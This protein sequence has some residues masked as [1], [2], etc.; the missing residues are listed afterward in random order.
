VT[1]QTN[2]MQNLSPSAGSAGVA[3][4]RAVYSKTNHEKAV[5]TELALRGFEVFLPTY[6]EVRSWSDRKKKL[7]LPLFP[8]Y[9]FVRLLG[10]QR[11]HVLRCPGVLG[12][13]SNGTTDASVPEAEI[14]GI[15]T[16]AQSGRD[17]SPAPFLQRG[18]RVVLAAG[19]MK[20][21]EGT[22][23]RQRGATRLVVSVSMLERALSVDVD[24]A[25]I[26]PC[27]T[28]LTP[29]LRALAQELKAAK[30]DESRQH[31]EAQAADD[32]TFTLPHTS[33]VNA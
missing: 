18:E 1:S 23:L 9:L 17:L 19:P 27:D 31:P 32:V 6:T 14:D 11:V 26:K 4:W 7:E 8:N 2:D 10:H 30:T 13:V 5:A 28:A 29:A 33:G 16:I 21:V 22:V 3:P 15:R 25:W 20:G 24:V 12:I